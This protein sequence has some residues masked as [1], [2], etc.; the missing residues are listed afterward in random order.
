MLFSS[1][2]IVDCVTVP[3][4]VIENW[5]S[6]RH[7]AVPVEL[8][9]RHTR[10]PP[11]TVLDG[12]LRTLFAAANDP[13]TAVVV[14][15]SS[16]VAAEAAATEADNV[17]IPVWACPPGPKE[18]TPDKA[19]EPLRNLVSDPYPVAMEAVPLAVT[20]LPMAI[21]PEPEAVQETP[22]ATASLTEAVQLDPMATVVAAE[23]VQLAP[24]ATALFAD[25]KQADPRLILEEP[26][27]LLFE[28]ISMAFVPLA[29]CML[30]ERTI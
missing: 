5:R 9:T 23:A 10:L 8:A 28:P 25:A 14:A 1:V 17:I 18:V 16:V 12:R 20:A 15:V 19:N 26:V 24:I 6:Y 11:K 27:E 3:A 21:E 4:D 30:L 7:R 13:A 2:P 29:T 22:I